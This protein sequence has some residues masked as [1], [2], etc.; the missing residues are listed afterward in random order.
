[1]AKQEEHLKPDNLWLNIKCQ[2][3]IHKKNMVNKVKYY[4]LTTNFEMI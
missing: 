3:L 1:M 4:L 2:L